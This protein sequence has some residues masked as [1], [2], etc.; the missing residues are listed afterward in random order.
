MI[1][2]AYGPNTIESEDGQWRINKRHLY[3]QKHYTL[4]RSGPDRVWQFVR[5]AV[6]L[7]ELKDIVDVADATETAA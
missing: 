5:N 7:Q 3:A 2:K 1:W 6:D 4:L